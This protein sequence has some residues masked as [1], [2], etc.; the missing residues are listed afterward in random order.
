[1]RKRKTEHDKAIEELEEKVRNNYQI[2]IRN[3]PY[4]F[5]YSQDVV[6]ELDLVGIRNGNWDIY[7]VK[8][9]DGYETAVKQLDRAQRLLSSCAKIRTFY[10]SGR[11][12]KIRRVHDYKRC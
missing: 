4:Y 2:T 1:M 5:P 10:Y 12:K 8:T 11:E 6:G 9:N 7:E 3:V